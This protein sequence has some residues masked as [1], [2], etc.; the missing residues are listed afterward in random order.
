MQGCCPAEGTRGS[1]R[2]P[3]VIDVPT[4]LERSIWLATHS[5]LREKPHPV[6]PCARL[7]RFGAI[8]HICYAVVG[9]NP[10]SRA[11]HPSPTNRPPSDRES[12]L[13]DADALA[14]RSLSGRHGDRRP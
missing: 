5:T 12:G 1:Y 6:T 4:A 9:S 13:P 8:L 11:W 14:R 3:I 2:R 10:V 7:E